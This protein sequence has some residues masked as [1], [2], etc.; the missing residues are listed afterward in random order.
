MSPGTPAIAQ[1][2]AYSCK[3][4]PRSTFSLLGE[5]QYITPALPGSSGLLDSTASYVIYA[6]ALHWLKLLASQVQHGS[7]F[8]PKR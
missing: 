3:P 1:G 2:K 5:D 4:P 6:Y 7:S 8:R